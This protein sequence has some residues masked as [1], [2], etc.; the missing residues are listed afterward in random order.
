MR[1]GSQPFCATFTAQVPGESAED[2]ALHRVFRRLHGARPDDLSGGL[3]LK[4]RGL[5]CE[6]VDAFFAPW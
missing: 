6:R 2:L 5:F 3:G 1:S 4:H